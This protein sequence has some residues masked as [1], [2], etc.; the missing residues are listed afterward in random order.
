MLVVE[1][2]SFLDS[3]GVSLSAF[4]G[5][6]RSAKRYKIFRDKGLRTVVLKRLKKQ[7]AR[8]GFCP[9]HP[10]IKLC[11]AAGKVQG[12]ES[13]LRQHFQRSGWLLLGPQDIVRELKLLRDSGYENA[14]A[15]V[16]AK[17][18]LRG[19]ERRKTVR[20]GVDAEVS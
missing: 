11:L 19:T 7:L 8:A 20:S 3:T 12:D 6:H 5:N 13:Q 14:V 1:C 17:L 18:L 15:S 16:V 4:Q 10:T 2:K 9:A